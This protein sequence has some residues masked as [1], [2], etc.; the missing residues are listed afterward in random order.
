MTFKRALLSGVT[1]ALACAP[2]FGDQKIQ[3]KQLPATPLIPANNLSELASPSISRNN[4]GLGGLATV[5]PGSGVASAAANAINATGGVLTYGMIGTSGATIPLNSSISSLQS[6]NVASYGASPAA[7][8]S[9]NNTA[10][11]AAFTAA[12]AAG[13][14]VL[15]PSGNYSLSASISATVPTTLALSIIGYGQENTVLAFS[16]SNGLNITLTDQWTSLLASDLSLTTD[17]TTGAYKAFQVTNPRTLTYGSAYPTGTTEIRNVIYRGADSATT[18]QEY[19]GKGIYQRNVS[20]INIDGG[21]FIGSNHSGAFLG[22]PIDLAGVV[23]PASYSTAISVNGFQTLFCHVGVLYGDFL[24]G[25]VVHGGSNFTFCQYGLKGLD[26]YV[27]TPDQFVMSDSQTN[28]SVAGIYSPVM[29]GLLV[30]HNTIIVTAGKGVVGALNAFSID[31]NFI[32]WGSGGV[33]GTGVEISSSSTVG[34]VVEGN[35][36]QNFTA[37][38]L[39]SAS[40]TSIASVRSNNFVGNTTNYSV[41]NNIAGV[42]IDDPGLLVV[43]AIGTQ[44]PTCSARYLGAT[45]K[46]YDVL[47]N[48]YLATLAGGGAGTAIGICNGTN[49]QVH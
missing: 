6:F 17:D 43:S 22:D 38:F 37:A 4:L 31:H 44:M 1:F 25:V 2:A 42:H 19:W 35:T 14:R 45:A 32:Q 28:T 11:Q 12:A 18:A 40:G 3:W 49:Y 36:F 27:G 24:Q 10:F 41:S 21:G 23:S 5:T 15:I 7:S 20:N 13:G 9:T 30:H 26:A 39:D 33:G 29:N 16:G 46:F 34:G 47:T 48:T 8:A